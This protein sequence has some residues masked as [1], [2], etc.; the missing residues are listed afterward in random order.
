MLTDEPHKTC[1]SKP[2]PA[3]G[4][5]RIGRGVSPDRVRKT[6]LTL[7][8]SSAGHGLSAQRADAVRAC[9]QTRSAGHG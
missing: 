2:C 6:R 7:S 1:V 8:E 9:F 4:A 3:D 5:W